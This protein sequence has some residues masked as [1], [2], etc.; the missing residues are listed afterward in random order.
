MHPTLVLMF[1]DAQRTELD[2]QTR[3]RRPASSRTHTR[4]ARGERS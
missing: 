3:G 4:R 2:R 1:L